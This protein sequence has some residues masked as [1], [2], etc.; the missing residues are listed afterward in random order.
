[1]LKNVFLHVDEDKE[2]QNSIEQHASPLILQREQKNLAA[3]KR[4]IPPVYDQIFKIHSNHI[5]ILCNKHSEINI[6]NTAE[7]RTF[8][9]LSPNAEVTEQVNQFSQR[10][11]TFSVDTFEQPAG[12]E[13]IA[14]IDSPIANKLYTSNSAPS[15]IPVL[16]VLGIGGALHLPELVKRYQ[17]DHLV[18]YEPEPA[19]FKCS[20]AMA[21]WQKMLGVAAEKNTA[22]YM[23]LG[24]DGSNLAD[25]LTELSSVAKFDEFTVFK[26]YNHPVFDQLINRLCEFPWQQFTQ[27]TV[28]PQPIAR[29]EQFLEEFTYPINYSEWS[30]T[31]LD[32]AKFRKNLDAFKKFIPNLYDE[33]NHYYPE[34][35]FPVAN[36]EGQVNLLNVATMTPLYGSNPQ[37]EHTKSIEVFKK[38]PNND[39]LV[40]NFTGKKLKSYLHY[41]MVAEV[42]EVL[43]EVEDEQRPLPETVKAI[44]I[45]GIG[46]GYG[47]EQLANE[48]RLEKVFICEPNR[49]FFYASL[50]AIDWHQIL[51]KI[52]QEDKRIYLNIGD[53]GTHLIEDLLTQFHTVGPYLLASTFF[54]QGYYN[55]YLTR[56]IQNL[57]EQLQ[58]IVSL[59]DYFDHSKYCIAHTRWG[60]E[61]EI[62]VLKA[63]AR[64]YLS[65]DEKDTPVFIV[66]NGPS[67]DNLIDLIQEYQGQAIIVSCGTAL[68][69]L[70]KHGITPDFHAEIE[71]NR[72]TYDWTVRVG[73]LDYLKKITLLSCNG[74]HPDTCN[75]F[76]DVYIAFKEGESA[77]VAISKLFDEFPYTRLHHAYPTVTNFVAN[78]FTEV[79]F[80]QL[81]LMGVDL[82]FIDVKHHHSKSSG[83]YSDDGKEIYD[84]AKSIKTTLTIEGNFRPF[85]KTKYEFRLAITILEKAL[86][87]ARDVYNLNDG[88]KIRGSIPLVKDHLMITGSR[89]G[90]QQ[91]LFNLKNKCFYSLASSTFTNS[92]NSKFRHDITCI[93]IKELIKTARKKIDSVSNAEAHLNEQRSFLIGSYFRQQSLL[94][95]YLNGS[96]NFI[97]S[98]MMKI[99]NVDDS[100]TALKLIRRLQEIWTYYLLQIQ[101]L[102]VNAARDFCYITNMGAERAPIILRDYLKNNPFKVVANPESKQPFINFYLEKMDLYFTNTSSMILHQNWDNHEPPLSCHKEINVLR[103]QTAFIKNLREKKVSVLLPGDWKEPGKPT[104]CNDFQ[105]A[106]ISFIASTASAKF[107][108]FLGRLNVL[109]TDDVSSLY[110]ID[111][112]SE[113]IVY[114]LGSAMLGLANEYLNADEQLLA[115]GT[116][117][118][119]IPRK[120]KKTDFVSHVIT[121]AESK[122]GKSILKERYKSEVTNDK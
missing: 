67:L 5:S 40:L 85:V 51:E 58:V 101:T 37:A 4:Y 93:E 22:I 17:I 73:D 96:F 35:W 111:I 106:A 64:Q 16:V 86:S 112:F 95:Y 65:A 97:S 19:Y 44:I 15:H 118:K 36:D 90:K 10:A 8:Y 21:D 27:K 60:M 30:R 105:R 98:A 76:K 121:G 92:F 69:T 28:K 104:F 59:G 38:Y 107:I 110:D 43:K 71:S 122:E 46:T 94:F 89:K 116:R 114:E 91:T 55:R 68:K 9:D 84:F 3:F 18:I 7:G 103:S 2:V 32:I 79:G 119:L 117:A 77:T 48:N 53:D 20:L 1:M 13:N 47:F 66:G 39:G 25:N 6:V 75:L 61:N 70:Y 41:Q 23:M 100:K 80:T 56:A 54:Y 12:E 81:Y 120:L 88:A 31:K 45:F 102:Q 99:V 109:E 87:R 11:L 82:G 74:I 34:F 52:E 62:P 113:F 26:H 49:D 42:D 57:R 63:D 108:G 29:S 33:F 72:A 24:E 83:Y 50:F 78:F 115:D 14:G